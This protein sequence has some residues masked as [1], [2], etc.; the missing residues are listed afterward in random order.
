MLLK[1]DSNRLRKVLLFA[2]MV[3]CGMQSA[4]TFSRGGL[5]Q[6][7][8]AVL[9]S[10]MYLLKDPRLRYTVLSVG[11]VLFLVANFVLLPYLDSFTGGELSSRFEDTSSTGRG[12]IFE[13]DLEIWQE[14]LILGV[15]PGVAT[16]IRKQFYGKSIVAH[17]EFSRVLA[18]HGI[19]GVSA[20]FVLMLMC[21]NRLKLPGT[22]RNR[23]IVAA[24]VTWSMVYLLVNAM[25]LAAPCFLFGLSFALLIPENAGR[26]YGTR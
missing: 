11:G 8:C 17:T 24:L 12:G 23:A 3:V 9:I 16:E 1:F 15:G 13:A 26:H 22:N 18:E 4:L 2:V 19:F 25:R 10:C 14:N 5:F 21:I 6:T 20:F 7:A